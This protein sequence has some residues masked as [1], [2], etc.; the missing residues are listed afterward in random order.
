[1]KKFIKDVETTIEYGEYD[2]F[3]KVIPESVKLRRINDN[4]YALIEAHN[5][6]GNSLEFT[7]DDIQSIDFESFDTTFKE[8]LDKIGFKE[9]EVQFYGKLYIIKNEDGSIIP[10]E[11]FRAEFDYEV[12]PYGYIDH[13][14]V[15]GRTRG[16]DAFLKY[17]G[18]IGYKSAFISNM[19]IKK[20]ED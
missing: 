5:L 20:I 14:V 9:N 12:M 13:K 2:N 4:I 3:V 10:F 18:Y 8:E 6:N 17:I 11:T 7:E 19:K 1:M 16:T 15:T